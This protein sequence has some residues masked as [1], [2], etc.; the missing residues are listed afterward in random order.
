MS[1]VGTK[2]ARKMGCIPKE[3]VFSEGNDTNQTA[4]KW[5]TRGHKKETAISKHELVLRF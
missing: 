3:K 5:G 1:H 4:E 2:S